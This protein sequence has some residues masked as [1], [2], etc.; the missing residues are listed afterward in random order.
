MVIT[1]DVGNVNVKLRKAGRWTALPAL[2]RLPER[3]GYS[4]AKES[5][6]RPLSYVSGPAK[7]DSQ[8]YLVGRDAERGGTADLAIIGSA[9]LRQRSDAYLLLHLWSILESLPAGTTEATIWYAGGVPVADYAE[10]GGE[11]L[12]LRLRGDPKKGARAHI[13]TWGNQEYRITIERAMIVPQPIGAVSTFLFDADGRPLTNGALLEQRAILDIGGGTT[14]YTI[15]R[16]L[17]L[18]PGTEGST[19]LGMHDAAERVVTMVRARHNLRHIEAGEIVQLLREGKTTIYVRG[20]PV[21][22]SDEIAEALRQVGAQIVAMLLPKWEKHLDRSAVMLVGGDAPRMAPA[23]R[24]ELEGMTSV[25][26][27]DKPLF[28]VVD[29]IDRLAK[30]RVQHAVA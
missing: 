12:K 9:Q 20:D 7:I 11:P 16:G 27:P 14:D 2:V 25:R 19:R 5:A 10:N 15:R 22:I 18:V 13:L 17:D 3:G 8:P 6:L 1:T 30:N 26:V 28:R 4:F 21:D 29:G 24:A 23:I